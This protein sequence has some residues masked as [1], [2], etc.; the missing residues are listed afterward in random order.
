M[1]PIMAN[2]TR[3]IDL[4]S[5]GSET[6]FLWG[7]RQSGKSTLLRERY[8]EAKWIDLLKSEVLRRY[9]TSPETLR[10]ELSRSRDR[11]VVVDEVQKAPSLLDE[12]HWLHERAAIGELARDFGLGKKE[13]QIR[14]GSSLMGAIVKRPELWELALAPRI[15]TDLSSDIGTPEL[16]IRDRRLRTIVQRAEETGEKH[17]L[18]DLSPLS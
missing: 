5:A 13:W 2:I 17:H 14:T 9:L 8:P 4:P 15:P 6:F 11:F 3:L 1:Q 7:P 10:E 12:A 18:S 16:L